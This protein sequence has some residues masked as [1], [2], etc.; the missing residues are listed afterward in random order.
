MTPCN[1]EQATH[2]LAKD[3]PQYLPLP[4][5]LGHAPEYRMTSCWQLTDEEIE[6]LVRTRRLWIQVLSFGAPMQPILPSADA[7]AELNRQTD[8][9]IDAQ[10]REGM[11]G[12]R[13]AGDPI[14][15]G[16]G[17]DQA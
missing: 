3:Q 13:D 15:G 17:G 16:D 8:A 10:I 12:L 9:E 2:T 6:Q 1:F 7:P 14:V 11:R 4:I 5:H